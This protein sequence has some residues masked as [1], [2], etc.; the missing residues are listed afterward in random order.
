MYQQGN[1]LFMQEITGHTGLSVATPIEEMEHALN[2][3]G[4]KVIS[5][6]TPYQKVADDM[7]ITYFEEIGFTVKQ[8][9]GFRCGSATDIAHVPEFAAE[10]V[11]RRLAARDEHGKP[12]AIVQCGTNLPMVGL[13]DRME[14]ELGLPILSTD[15]SFRLDPLPDWIS[16]TDGL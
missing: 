14:Q 7:V 1:Q 10:S 2:K 11:L 16:E 3:F 6:V 5:V 9:H 12:D 8:I 13:C 15:Q 4:A